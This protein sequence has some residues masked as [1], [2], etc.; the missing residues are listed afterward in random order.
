MANDTEWFFTHNW[1]LISEHTTKSKGELATESGISNFNGSA[2]TWFGR[3][4]IQIVQ[5]KKCGKLK[6]FVENI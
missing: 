4:F 1:E 5:C 3:K 2:Q 6:R